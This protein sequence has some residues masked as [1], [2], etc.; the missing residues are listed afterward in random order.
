[1]QK[2]LPNRG[3][4]LNAAGGPRPGAT[5]PSEPTAYF[6][7]P[8]ASR[9]WAGRG[10]ASP[11]VFFHDSF[12]WSLPFFAEHFRTRLRQDNPNRDG[13]RFFDKELIERKADGW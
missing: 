4:L 1:M 13:T 5:Y 2:F 9:S 3:L 10:G 7:P 12:F 8:V 6:Q 11:G